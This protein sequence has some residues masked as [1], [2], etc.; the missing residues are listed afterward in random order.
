[1]PTK[2]FLQEQEQSGLASYKAELAEFL[3]LMF[4]VQ[5]AAGGMGNDTRAIVPDHSCLIIGFLNGDIML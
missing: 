5:N 1:M 4:Q 3:A 2:I